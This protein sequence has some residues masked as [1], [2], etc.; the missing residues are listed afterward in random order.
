MNNQMLIVKAVNFMSNIA[1]PQVTLGDLLNY[2]EIPVPERTD[3]VVLEIL[4][5]MLGFIN[6]SATE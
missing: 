6:N 1:S 2:L 4:E 5:S 3:G